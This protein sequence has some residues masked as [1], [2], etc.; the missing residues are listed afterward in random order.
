MQLSRYRPTMANS[1]L[2]TM[3]FGGLRRRNRP[4]TG[5]STMYMAVMKPALPAS[6]YTRPTCCRLA[7]IK[8]AAPQ[9]MPAFHRA[10]FFH[11]ARIPDTPNFFRSN[12]SEVTRRNTTARAQRM[13][14]KVKGP[15]WFMP[16]LCAIKAEPQITVPSSR[17]RLP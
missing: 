3:V 4:I 9:I 15:I 13:V 12:S 7:A 17:H 16:S 1:T 6:V 11:W 14:W 10:G 8:S 2:N 5:T